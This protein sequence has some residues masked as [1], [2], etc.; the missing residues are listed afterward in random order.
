[1]SLLEA[2][3]DTPAAWHDE[4]PV[5]N[6]YTFGVAGERFFRAIKDEGRILGTHCSNCDR[7]YVPA[8]I[9][10][11]RCLH[12]T[13]EWVEVGTVGE[14]VT[15][16]ELH[17]AYDGSPLS[18][19][20]LIALVKFGDGGLIH[21]LRVDDPGQVEIGQQARAVFK[22]S[23]ERQGSILDISHFELVSDQ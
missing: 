13:D 23:G 17:I 9:F 22:P 8:A 1:M 5:S 2:G 19:P 14:I 21:R 6:R 16:T 18:E 7:T 11:E 15:F 12:E 4:M 3:H 10:C 20:E